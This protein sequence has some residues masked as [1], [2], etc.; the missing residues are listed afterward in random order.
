M[1]GNA[2]YSCRLPARERVFSPKETAKEHYK[3]HPTCEYCGQV[4]SARYHLNH[5]KKTHEEK[6]LQCNLC[7]KL[8]H[9]GVTTIKSGINKGSHRTLLEGNLKRHLLSHKKGELFRYE[10]DVGSCDYK[11]DRKTI[12]KRHKNFHFDIRSHQCNESSCGKSFVTIDGLK[13]HVK[14]VHHKSTTD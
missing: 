4:F 14:E 3:I 2:A 10:C 6:E 8:I 5:H 9:R 11:T 1:S 13:R 12:L 7:G